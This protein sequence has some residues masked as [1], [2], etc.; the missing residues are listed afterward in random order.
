MLP[1]VLN[2]VYTPLI[3]SI[4]ETTF[5]LEQTY[6]YD[7]LNKT[8]LTNKGKEILRA[9]HVD[10][11]AQKAYADLCEH[12]STS[13]AAVI[14]AIDTYKY[15]ITAKIE[16]WRGDTE[17]FIMHWFEQV[18]LYESVA[19][20]DAYM[21]E[22]QKIMNLNI[23]VQSNRELATVDTTF[24]SMLSLDKTKVPTIAQFKD[25][26]ISAAVNYDRAQGTKG[27]RNGSKAP[28]RQVYSHE[29]KPTYNFDIDTPLLEVMRAETTR[30]GDLEAYQSETTDRK[31][32]RPAPNP[33]QRKPT[34][35]WDQWKEL[36]NAAR[37]LWDK[38]DDDNKRVI[39]RYHDPGRSPNPRTHHAN[40]H[41]IRA[42]VD[43]DDGFTQLVVYGVNAHHRTGPY[44]PDSATVNTGKTTLTTKSS[45]TSST[46]STPSLPPGHPQRMLS[47]QYSVNTNQSKTVRMT[48]DNDTV[49]F[50]ANVHR[51]NYNITQSVTNKRNGSL[52][53]RGAN[54]G[55]GGTDVRKLHDI[56]NTVVKTTKSAIS[57]WLSSPV[58]FVQTEDPSWA[59]LTIM[60]TSVRDVLFIP[61]LNSNIQDTM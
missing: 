49:I 60:P 22:Q 51:I 58:S 26:L 41:D 43:D 44:T 31:S 18:R 25:L 53:D 47:P 21:T 40:Y 56:A 28:S 55:I 36:P 33:S 37:Q 14:D 23:A 42:E 52:V 61:H 1:N 9:H 5:N 13:T 46:G 59:F 19:E 32:P 29:T 35:R 7:V 48:F 27:G 15:I 17:K 2:P 39:L 54:G 11:N 34:L 45:S 12:Y 3:G 10:R 57:P 24:K 50:D 4:D 8:V 38:L 20:P 6:M 16:D 30:N